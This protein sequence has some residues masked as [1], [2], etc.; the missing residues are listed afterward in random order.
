MDYIK[1][2]SIEA[3]RPDLQGGDNIE[4]R[5][6]EALCEFLRTPTVKLRIKQANPHERKQLVDELT[7]IQQ[8]LQ[9]LHFAP[10]E[11]PAPPPKGTE[12]SPETA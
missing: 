4:G 3:V 1:K 9:K 5:V 10:P 11:I 2:G 6:S 8:R 7:A 12:I